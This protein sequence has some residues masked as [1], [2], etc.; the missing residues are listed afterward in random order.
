[1]Q[2]FVISIQLYAHLLINHDAALATMPGIWGI[3]K[4]LPKKGTMGGPEKT[5][6]ELVNLI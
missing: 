4:K 5:K 6:T 1:M 2:V 3:K